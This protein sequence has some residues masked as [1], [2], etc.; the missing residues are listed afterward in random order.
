MGRSRKWRM[1]QSFKYTRTEVEPI[2]S[3][4]IS[5]VRTHHVDTFSQRKDWEISSVCK[6]MKGTRFGVLVLSP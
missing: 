6:K 4:H 5:L 2:T 1:G 3:T